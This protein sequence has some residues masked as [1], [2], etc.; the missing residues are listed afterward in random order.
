[1][2]VF[3]S[4]ALFNS[5]QTIRKINSNPVHDAQIE[6]IIFVRQTHFLKKKTFLALKHEDF[7]EMYFKFLPL[8][9]IYSPLKIFFAKN[10]LKFSKFYNQLLLYFHHPD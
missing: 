3:I 5:V 10:S 9:F 8:F 6:K 1:M 7:Y 2:I 4:G